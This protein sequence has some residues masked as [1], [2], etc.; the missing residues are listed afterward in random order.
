M[1]GLALGF[2]EGF[3]FGLGFGLLLAFALV[4][5]LGWVWNLIGSLLQSID[6]SR[7]AGQGPLACPKDARSSGI[8]RPLTWCAA[9]LKVSSPAAAVC[10]TT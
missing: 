6:S 8:P 5:G 7:A 4:I 10:S 3:G 9:S 1:H 2:G